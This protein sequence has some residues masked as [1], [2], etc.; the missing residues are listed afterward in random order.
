[1]TDAPRPVPGLLPRQKRRASLRLRVV[2]AILIAGLAPQL[3][4][5]AWSQLDRPVLG[6]LW[7][8][9]RDAAVRAAATLPAGGAAAGGDAHGDALRAVARADRVRVRVV[10][11][12]GHVVADVDEQPPEDA[13]GHI[14]EFFVG[15]GDAPTVAELDEELGPVLPRPEVQQAL[16]DGVYV[17]CSFVPIAYCQAAVRAR[18]SSGEACIVHAQAGS[19]RAV[20]AVYGLRRQLLRLAAVTVPLALVLALYMGGRVVRPIE[21]LRRQALER[22]TSA[23]AASTPGGALDLAPNGHDEVAVLGAAFNA[24][25]VALERRRA[26]NEAF[27][28]DLV[29]EMKSPVAAVRAAAD[30]LRSPNLDAARA[31]RLAR[32][33]DDSASKLDRLVSHFLDLARAEAGMN[34]ERRDDVDLAA[35]ARGL[36]AATKDDGRH[37]AVT[38]AVEGERGP[39]VV[40]G[41]EYRLEALLRELL[42]NGASF[43]GEGG[44]VTVRLAARA[45]GREREVVVEVSD[46]GPGIR[47]EDL[48]RVFDRFF[49]TRGEKRGT[50][51]G[52]ALVRAVARAH[53][54][55]ATVRSDAGSGATF[56]VTLPLASR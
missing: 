54:G 52:L 43:A 40:R 32:V 45:D 11:L 39:L 30:A 21:G 46:T 42:E 23:S 13:I 3:V 56:V 9:T 25:L 27:V 29:H 50:G 49:T 18:T 28:A 41:V 44:A 10:D 51:V 8:A 47:S 34:D 6:Q 17:G 4:V 38:F 37:A 26:D 19:K 33:V 2:L 24:L 15:S 22:A 20:A 1:M 7:G 5:F 16:R 14:E 12:D 35:L 36:V 48:P 53:G 31:S 55:E